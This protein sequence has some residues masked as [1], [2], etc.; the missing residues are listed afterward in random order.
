MST[1]QQIE[2][3][4][5]HA[6][7]L[8]KQ[9]S[10]SCSR[11]L[12]RVVWPFEFN[13]QAYVHGPFAGL[14]KLQYIFPLECVKFSAAVARSPILEGNFREPVLRNAVAEAQTGRLV[15]VDVRTARAPSGP[16]INFS[17]PLGHGRQ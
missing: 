6:E 16:Q 10:D 14:G 5:H 13:R 12:G 4:L 1:Q 2:V 3:R 9:D 7:L 17:F 11:T 15:R 8:L